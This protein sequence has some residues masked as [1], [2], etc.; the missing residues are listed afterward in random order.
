MSGQTL[1]TYS[2]V[3]VDSDAALSAYVKQ[4]NGILKLEPFGEELV[5][6]LP[7]YMQ[8]GFIV[9]SLME[10]IGEEF[11]VAIDAS[12]DLALQFSVTTATWGLTYWEDLLGL[13][14]RDGE[15]PNTRRGL[16]LAALQSR[17]Q[18]SEGAFKR[19]LEDTIG[20]TVL[21]NPYEPSIKPYT[22]EV[23]AQVDIVEDAPLSAPVATDTG[24]AGAL[25]G[26]YSYKIT[27]LFGTGETDSGLSESNQ[28]TVTNEQVLLSNIPVSIAPNVIGRRVYR[29]RSDGTDYHFVADIPNNAPLPFTDNVDDATVA[30]APILSLTSTALNT[31][32]VRLFTIIAQ[33]KPAHIHVEVRGEAFRASINSAGDRV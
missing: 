21:I 9:R 24:T 29:K 2:E 25:D 3:L 31:V 14:N 13:A 32:G 30:A 20:G 33:A 16:V 15:D 11:Q 4:S 18:G 19:L 10:A 8:D 17:G 12:D 28:V 26:T 1:T 6:Y 22:I 7:A 23:E 27:Y 5:D